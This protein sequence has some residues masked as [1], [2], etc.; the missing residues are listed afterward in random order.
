MIFN[1]L[2]LV[3][4]FPKHM[5]TSLLEYVILLPRYMNWSTDFKELFIS[6]KMDLALN[7]LQRFICHKTHTNKQTNKQTSLI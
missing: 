5:L 7:N 6:I 4:G 1:K 3:H 2:E